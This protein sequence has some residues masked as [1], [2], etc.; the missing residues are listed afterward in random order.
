MSLIIVLNPHNTVTICFLC[1]LDHHG[2]PFYGFLAFLSLGFSL[3]SLLLSPPPINPSYPFFHAAVFFFGGLI[4]MGF[5]SRG[6]RLVQSPLL[7]FL[8]AIGSRFEGPLR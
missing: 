5:I 2:S 6:V 4:G 1:I 7:M 8:K 3:F